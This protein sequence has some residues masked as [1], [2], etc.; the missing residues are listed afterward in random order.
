[1]WSVASSE[2]QAPHTLTSQFS[3]VLPAQADQYPMYR[4]KGP[5]GIPSLPQRSDFLV[6]VSSLFSIVS[7][8]TGLQGSKNYNSP[9]C[10]DPCPRVS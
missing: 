8:I 1:M 10:G 2:N 5:Q 7:E 6:S 3:L 4:K 9:S